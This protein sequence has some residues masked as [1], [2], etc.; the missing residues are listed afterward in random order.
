MEVSLLVDDAAGSGSERPADI[1]LVRVCVA[2]EGCFGVLLVDGVPAGPITL[3]R[4]YPLVENQPR[5][6]QYVKIPTGRYRCMRT[7][8]WRHGYETY[9]VTGVPAHD[10]L[11]FH[12]ANEELDL[13]GCIGVGMRFGLLE[14]RPAILDSREGFAAFMRLAFGRKDFDLV[15]RAA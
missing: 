1:E 12:V 2:P 13:D 9:E 4:T 11:L 14:G 15:V 3:E 8:Y 10:R 5:G 6:P 7:T